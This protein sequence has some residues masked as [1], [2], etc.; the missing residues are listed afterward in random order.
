[1]FRRPPDS[2]AKNPQPRVAVLG[3][4]PVGLEAALYARALGLPVNLFEAGQV[5]E[6]VNRWGF[7]R[8]FTP[9]GWNATPLGRRAVLA[10]KPKHTFPAETD[11]LTGREFRD[12][13][14][15]P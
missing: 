6:F 13:Y 15:L 11:L 4:G 5:G 7:V 9:F 14:L 2:P 3:G 8:L 1:M 12:A 10:D